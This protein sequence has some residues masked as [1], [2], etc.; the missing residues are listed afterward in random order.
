MG[1]KCVYTYIYIYIYIYIFDERVHE[2]TPEHIVREEINV[3]SRYE[4]FEFFE[5]CNLIYC[6]NLSSS[7]ILCPNS[8][9]RLVAVFVSSL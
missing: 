6:S 3:S 2:E 1:L 9:S 7:V 4:L 8:S 5:Q